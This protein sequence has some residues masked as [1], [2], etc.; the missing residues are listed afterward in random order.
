M[1]FIVHTLLVVFAV[2]LAVSHP[3][4]PLRTPAALE[5]FVP[6]LVLPVPD[7]VVLPFVPDE[8]PHAV[9]TMSPLA[10]IDPVAHALQLVL[11]PLPL[12]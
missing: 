12:T 5:Q 10:L 8:L 1:L 2:Q 11:S 7:A 6:Q 3:S 4:F 9:H